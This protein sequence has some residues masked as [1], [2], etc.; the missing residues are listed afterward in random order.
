MVKA[1]VTSL[2]PSPWHSGTVPKFNYD[3]H[4]QIVKCPTSDALHLR[5]SRM[6]SASGIRIK[7]SLFRKI[8]SGGYITN[9]AH[10]TTILPKCLQK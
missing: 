7:G 5:S 3:D 10:N 1:I 8:L 6:R 4:N 9:F 2:L